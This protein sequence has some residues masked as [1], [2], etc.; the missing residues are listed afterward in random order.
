MT[1]MAEYNDTAS[2]TG[3]LRS[4]AGLNDAHRID[5]AMDAEVQFRHLQLKFARWL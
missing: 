1:G 2:D 5:S 3:N 4:A